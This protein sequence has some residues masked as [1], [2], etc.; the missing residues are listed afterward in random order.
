MARKNSSNLEVIINA[1]G[2]SIGGGTTKRTATFSGDDFDFVGGG[3]A[4]IT[5]PQIT[6]TLATLKLEENVPQEFDIVLSADGKYSGYVV[7]GV[8]GGSALAFGDLVYLDTS[9]PDWELADASA[10]STSGTKILG[11][12]VQAASSTAATTVLLWGSIRADTAFPTFT[13][14][15]LY[16]SETAG[17][18]TNTAPT[19]TDAVVR[20]V[21]H[22]LTGDA[23]FFNPSPNYIT[24]V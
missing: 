12:C 13:A 18:I 11:I 7:A 24:A 2:F 20:V 21:G 9:M 22:A 1:D 19:T 17:D 6:G 16:V 8:A 10:A 23:M 14:G 4:V 5:F 3:S 15:Q